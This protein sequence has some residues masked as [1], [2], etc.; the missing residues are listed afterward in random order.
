MLNLHLVTPQRSGEESQ[1]TRWKP[2]IRYLVSAVKSSGVCPTS[3]EECNDLQ[4]WLNPCPGWAET[5]PVCAQFIFINLPLPFSPTEH[6]VS[7]ELY[8]TSSDPPSVLLPIKVSLEFKC[9]MSPTTEETHSGTS[10][11]QRAHSL[12]CVVLQHQN[13]VSLHSWHR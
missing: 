8:G 9:F 10:E 12:F 2:F 3:S 7:P 1:C 13:H 4:W 6:K 11:V 5:R